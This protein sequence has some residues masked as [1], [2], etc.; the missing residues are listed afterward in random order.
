VKRLDEYWW[1]RN[2]IAFLLLPLSWL[3]CLVVVVRRFAY[4]LGLMRSTRLPVPV[5][6]V[7]NI[8]VGGTGKTPLVIWIARYLKSKGYKPGII[9]R[10]YGGKASQWP[11]QVREGSDP[12][13]VGD[14]A[15]LLAR[16]TGCPMCVGPDRAKAGLA[17]VANTDCD[18]VLSDDGLQHYGLKRDIEIA[19]LDG[20]RGLGNGF[21]LP[22]GPLREAPG[23]LDEV[24]MVVSNGIAGRR[25]FRMQLRQLKAVNIAD[26]EIEKPLS[27]FVGAEPVHA[28][29]GI[30]NPERFFSQLE[31]AGITVIRHPFPDHHLFSADDILP[32]DDNQVLMT[33]KDA[34]K[35]SRFAE[36]RHWLIRIEA[37]VEEQFAH[38]LDVLIGGTANG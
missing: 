27:D 1:D 12:V 14:E 8:T 7:G 29:A 31:R 38:R 28:M 36:S 32:N 35:C 25:Q 24:D 30:G 10:G 21:C 5:I 11:Q 37:V 22:A 13:T 17:L 19:V 20:E 18:I 34:V 23:R 9:S 15:I 33:E 4:R 3:F 2:G 26:S 16:H 6:V